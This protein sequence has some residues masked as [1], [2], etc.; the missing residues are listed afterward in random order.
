[1]KHIF[2]WLCL[3]TQVIEF[4][5]H[6]RGLQVSSKDL[7]KRCKTVVQ[8]WKMRFHMNRNFCWITNF[9][10]LTGSLFLCEVRC[11]AREYFFELL[12]LKG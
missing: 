8:I 3:F 2:R 12:I 6:G 4:A 1:M 10:G 7:G 11:K 5:L 9:S